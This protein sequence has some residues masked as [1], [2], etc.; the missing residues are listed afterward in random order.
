MVRKPRGR[1]TTISSPPVDPTTAYALAVSKGRRPDGSLAGE[2]EIGACKRH[3]HDLEHGVD[4]GLRWE[5]DRAAHALGF[6]PAVLTVTAGMKEGH[7]YELLDWQG[8]VVGSI[9]GW[10]KTSGRL[11]FR[12][13]W[14]ET[15][16]G[17]AKSPLMGAIGI[18]LTGYYGVARA[19]VY[20]IGQDRRTANVLFRDAV[21]MCRA[22]IPGGDEYDTLEARGE[23]IIRG[24]HDNA[25]K[26]EHPESASIF[27][28][29]AN[30]ETVS[31][32]RPVA[33]LADEIHE[34]K[35]NTS[36]E[37]WKGAIAKMP[38]DALMLLGTNTP[39]SDQIIGTDYSTFYQKVA[40]GKLFDD[41]AFAFIARV[42]VKDRET[43]F[44][45][46]DVWSKSLPALGITFPRENIDGMVNTAKSM[47]STAISTKRL[48]FGI[49]IGTSEFWIAEDAWVAVQGK[50]DVPAL[51]GCRCWLSLDLSQKNDLTALTCVWIDDDGHLWAKT[52]YWTVKARLKE[53]AIADQAPYV[54]WVEAELITAVDGAVIDKTFIAA[55][56][57]RI[58][59]EQSVEFLAFDAAGM[60]DFIAACETIGFPVWKWEGPDKPEGIGLKL[61]SHAQGNRVRFEDRQLTMPRSI[62]RLEDRILAETITI[63]DSPVTYSCAANAKLKPDGQGNRAFDKK[64]SRGRMDGVVTIAMGVGA[65]DNEMGGSQDIDS[66]LANPVMVG[67]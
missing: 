48:Y 50:V 38:G 44:E 49:P 42:D 12:S 34:F 28:V 8:F 22:P 36:I 56:V 21:A 30:G 14:L 11:R 32:P 59:M 23:V 26:I 4:R 33:V 39:A 53:R 66:F 40:T 25:W 1:Q 51:K 16:K 58:C 45:T 24:E 20:A 35:S 54:E 47:L 62:E 55:E 3:L 7:P 67:V 10:R 46:P 15:G 61:V 29:L 37:T 27:Q 6:F 13:V 65:A 19:E 18:Y 57:Q 9:F 63:E 31:G 41:E 43:I 52:W 64:A 17:Q 60:A 2:F 5:P